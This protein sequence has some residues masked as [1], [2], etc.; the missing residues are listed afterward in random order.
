MKQP[1]TGSFQLIKNLNI[2]CVLETIRV[3]D[4]ISRAEI[5]RRTGL[6]PATVSNITGELIKLGLVEEIQRGISSGGRKPVLISI[7]KTM[8]FFGSIHIGSN[9]IE[10]A[11]SD[12]D[13]NIL[14]NVRIPLKAGVSPNEVLAIAID[15]LRDTQ[16]DAD[17]QNLV[18]I[19]V[20]MH[21]LV[22]S[23]AGV[24]VFAPN[25][26]W[27]DV[28]VGNPV[29]KAFGVPVFVENDVR[30]MTLAENWCGTAR[31]VKDYVY[32]YIG[33]GIGG[34]IVF[35]N[36]LYKGQGSFAGEFGHSTIVPDGPQCSC[37][38]HG[39]LQA[40]A[41]ETT[42]MDH[43][44]KRKAQKGQ[45]VKDDLDFDD[46]IAGAQDGDVDAIDEIR[47]S[48]R[49]IGIEVVNIINAFSPSLI[50]IN[51][52]ITK[53]SDTVM[54]ELYGE[55]SKRSMRYS[56]SNTKIVFSQ[57]GD[58]API[59]GA[60]TCIIRKMFKSPKKFLATVHTS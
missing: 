44:V 21:G 40:L 60:A 29:K 38:N 55:I 57:L 9:M 52:R 15:K 39:C 1:V 2:S 46:I 14:R 53:L 37:G 28:Q 27:K 5:A 31:K 10:T 17:V 36:E 42:M 13:A 32:L 16:K 50:V 45:S 7:R 54:S 43:Y 23:E 59:R 41:S 18:G 12:I 30:A 11:I 3:N 49:Y 22:D 48:A 33:P 25:L 34:S 26:G 4:L 35:G 47:T 8:C 51:G 6:T 24:S 58:A 19:G 56:K 20:C